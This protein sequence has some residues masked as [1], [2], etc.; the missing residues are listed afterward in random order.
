MTLT[1]RWLAGL[2]ARRRG[3]LVATAIGVALTVSLLAA[4]G[5][6]LS[7]STAAMTERAISRVPLDWQ[8]QGEV[9]TDP[10]TLLKGV[11]AFPQIKAALPVGYGTTA[12]YEA[13]SAGKATSA[14]PGLILGIAADYRATFPDEFTQL[15]GSENGVLMAQQLAANLGVTIGDTVMV[16]RT[17][18]PPATIRVD[19]IIDLP[20]ADALFQTVGLPPGAPQP[21]PPDNVMLIPAPQW[22]Q[23][24]DPL[25]AVSQD[26]VRTQ[27]HANVDHTTLPRDPAAAYTRAGGLGRNLEASLQGTGLVGNNLAHALAKARSDSAYARVVFLFLGLPGA[28][29]AGLITA[30]IAGAGATRRRRDQALLRTRGATTRDLVRLALSE[31]ALVAAVGGALGL[32]GALLIGRLAFGTKG[33]GATSGQ[34]ALWSAGAVVAGVIVA[35]MAIAVPAWRDARTLTIASARQSVGRARN[36]W[37]LRYGLD[38]ICLVGAGFVFWSTGSNGYKLVLAVEGNTQVSVNYYSFL[39]P[40]LLWIGVGLLTWRI[41]NLVLTHGRGLLTRAARPLAG[42]LAGTVAATMTRQRRQLAGALSLVALTVG[43]AASTA[44]FNAT[45]KQQAEV[46]ARLSKGADVVV[47]ES[48]GVRVGPDA[49]AQ[50]AAIPGVQSVEPLQHRFAY[51]GADLQDL[52][53]VNAS[54]IVKN[55]QLQDGFFEGGS[56]QALFTQLAAKPDAILVSKEAVIDFQLSPGDPINLRI[57]DGRTKRSTPVRFTYVGIAKKFPSAPSDS[58]FVA[59]ATYVAQQTNN[60][61]VGTFLIQTGST[62]PQQVAKAVAAKVGTTALVSDITS[63]RRKIAGSITSTELAGLT[64]VELSFALVLLGASTGLLLWLGLA[65]RKRTFAIAHALGAKQRQLGS[66]IWAELTFVAVGGLVL[67][68]AAAWGLATML[69]KV[70]TG[71]FDPPPSAL[72]IPWPYLGGVGIVAVAGVVLA[73]LA[74][75]RIAKRPAIEALRD[76]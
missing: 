47:T 14:G 4:I 57:Q 16:K 13:T 37:W 70:L 46:D 6:F 75:L 72:A 53:G 19:G 34:T 9:G 26:L 67:G 73:G 23:I 50:F 58:F 69:V 43:F 30:A 55:A 2:I 7:G 22:H 8:V 51:I 1:F 56:A 35:A 62:P 36:P 71:V 32:L 40:L 11:K 33:F 60:N 3:R 17:G 48:P 63:K 42:G 68:A 5:S 61:A 24:F 25:A 44:A 59:N 49:A 64:R 76:L 74:A 12:G 31:T 15:I 28:V 21:P 66:F 54:T 27:I 20:A 65:E 52:Y 45:Y 29:L 18:L 38:V 41:A 39:A 10:T